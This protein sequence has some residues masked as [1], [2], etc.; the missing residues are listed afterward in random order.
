[1]KDKKNIIIILLIIIVIISIIAI[2]LYINN[3]SY[4][5]ENSSEH[6]EKNNKIDKTEY[7]ETEM[8]EIDDKMY[9]ELDTLNNLNSEEAVKTIALLESN[10]Y[11]FSYDEMDKLQ[12]LTVYN[13]DTDILLSYSILYMDSRKV[14]NM[15]FLNAQI[16]NL[17]YEFLHKVNGLNCEPTL[18]S[19]ETRHSLFT[20]WLTT[21]HLTEKQIVNMLYCSEM[22]K[23][24]TN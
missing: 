16:N 13:Y 8:Q 3:Y 12:R 14:E 6:S 15:T 7:N 21:M 23:Y 17:D 11:V 4:K 9:S 2:N 18:S 19:N 22:I 1:M 20:T 24:E 10:N 5:E